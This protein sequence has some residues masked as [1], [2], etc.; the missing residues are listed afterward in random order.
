MILAKAFFLGSAEPK[1]AVQRGCGISICGG[2]QDPS[3]KIHSFPDLVLIIIPQLVR[4]CTTWR[5]EILSNQCFCD[6]MVRPSVIMVFPKTIIL[7]RKIRFFICFQNWQYYLLPLYMRK[8]LKTI[9]FAVKW[10][11]VFKY[12]FILGMYASFAKFFPL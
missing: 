8:L 10:F 1:R 7:S 4:D 5:P 11:L 12:R 3:R 2:L 6:S 9:A